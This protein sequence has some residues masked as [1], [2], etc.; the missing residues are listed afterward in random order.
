MAKAKQKAKIISEAMDLT[1]VEAVNRALIR[2][3][4][5]DET[6]IV[7]G[8]DVAIRFPQFEGTLVDERKGDLD[9]GRVF[10]QTFCFQ[11]R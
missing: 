6:V 5:E 7:L 4:A 9:V 2:A 11:T 10:A 8:Q 3:M 1:M